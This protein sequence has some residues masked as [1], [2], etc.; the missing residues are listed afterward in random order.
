MNHNQ[1]GKSI[2]ISFSGSYGA[3]FFI[4]IL[5]EICLQVLPW[6]DFRGLFKTSLIF[7]ERSSMLKGF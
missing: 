4:S 2:I 7:F 1:G 6:V 3:V 5:N